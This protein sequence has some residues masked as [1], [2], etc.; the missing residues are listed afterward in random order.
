MKAALGSPAFLSGLLCARGFS[1]LLNWRSQS[2][3]ERRTSLLAGLKK[4]APLSL[5]K[6]Y[7]RVAPPAAIQQVARPTMLPVYDWRKT[8]AFS[9]PTD[10]YGWI[11][12]NLKGRE[13]KGCVSIDRYM[14]TRAELETMLRELKNLDGELL[15]RD[16][17]FTTSEQTALEHQLPDIVVHWNDAAFVPDLRIA[18]TNILAQPVGIKTGQHA[19]NGFC[20][21]DSKQKLNSE[22]PL[23]AEDM[24]RL[25]AQ[26]AQG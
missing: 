25:L 24:G 18:G 7:Y 8:R 9:L 10:Q 13:A 1:H 3:A 20:V 2:W 12:I 4:K 21:I 6:F 22:H 11:R 26:L 17:V 19:L 15:V 14:E 23:L 5:R 16:L